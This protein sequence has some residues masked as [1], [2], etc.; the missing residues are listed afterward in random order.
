MMRLG[1]VRRSNAPLLIVEL[2]L[3]GL[4]TLGVA[5]AED[6]RRLGAEEIQSRIIGRVIEEDVARH[7]AFYFRQGGLL[8]LR[9]LGKVSSGRWEM[10]SSALCIAAAADEKMKCYEVWYS[11]AHV[12]L[13]TEGMLDVYGTIETFDGSW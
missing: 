7:W 12:R 2:L 11:S 13:R 5:K 10:Q 8:S 4:A 1:A 6:F 3:G 9:D